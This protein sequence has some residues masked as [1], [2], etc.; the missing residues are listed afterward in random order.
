VHLVPILSALVSLSLMYALPG[1]TWIRLFV[2]M[3][4]GM[5]I[6]FTYGYKHSELRKTGQ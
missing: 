6:Y 1:E 3:A 5:V 2:W 4:I